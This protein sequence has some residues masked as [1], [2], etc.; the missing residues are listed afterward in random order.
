[1]KLFYYRDPKGNFGDDLNTWIWDL[2]LPGFRQAHPEVSLIGVGTLLNSQLPLPS[3]RK[4]VLGTGTGYG[5]LPASFPEDE[6]DLRSVRGPDSAE[7]IGLPLERGILDPAVMLPD[8]AGLELPEVTPSGR[9]L[10]IPHH[11]NVHR[12][13]WDSVCTRA[14]V[15]YLSPC[16]EAKFVIA[17]IASAPL[18]LAESM[19][20][21]IIADAYR[22]PW[23]A[24]STSGNLNRPKWMDW[25]R[26]VGVDLVL[27]DLFPEFGQAAKALRKLRGRGE[28]MTDMVVGGKPLPVA[29]E[30]DELGCAVPPPVPPLTGRKK[31]RVSLERPFLTGRLR[32][33]AKKPSQL[34]DD[35]TLAAARARY[36]TVLEEVRA[37]YGLVAPS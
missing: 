21:A 16:E 5:T 37:D 34:S 18:V 10:F 1:M 26:S 17:R 14:G 23:I 35:A 33:L 27:H 29:C 30:I 13:P 19:H 12:H 15:D 24:V 4:L 3:G 2:L 20:A 32:Q 28:P 31:L 11:S 36:R 25:A 22:V 8:L 6:W 9:P 7:R